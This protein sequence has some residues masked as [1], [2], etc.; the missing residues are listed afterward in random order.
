MK[1]KFDV[2]KFLTILSEPRKHKKLLNKE[3]KHPYGFE[4]PNEFGLDTDEYYYKIPDLITALED[5]GYKDLIKINR[6]GEI[7]D[8][9]ISLDELGKDFKRLDKSFNYSPIFH[10]RDAPEPDDG[11]YYYLEECAYLSTKKVSIVF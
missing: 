10:L 7:R 6:A 11:I 9:F 4:Y 1:K 3:G 5:A 8:I 2:N